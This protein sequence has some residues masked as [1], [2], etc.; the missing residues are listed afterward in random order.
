MK[1]GDTLNIPKMK[2]YRIGSDPEA[3]F[4]RP[5]DF[6]WIITPAFDIIGRDKKKTTNSFIGTDNR[7]VIAEI[8]PNPSRNLKRHLYE[9][10]YALTTTNDYLDSS[11]KWKGNKIMAYPYLLGE[12]LGGHIHASMFLD[13]PIYLKLKATGL[14]VGAGGLAFADY[15]GNVGGFAGR[16]RDIETEATTAI[17]ERKIIT[18]NLWGRAMGFLL[19]PFEKW[20]QPW[21]AR[22]ARNAHYGS[23]SSPDAVRLGTSKVPFELSKMAYVHWEYR[24]PS[25]W[26]QHP[27]LAYAYLGLA[28]LTL[29]N[30]AAVFG[31]WLADN[32][33]MKPPKHDVLGG[34]LAEPTMGDGGMPTQF[35]ILTHG[36]PREAGV[37]FRR[38]LSRVLPGAHFSRDLANLIGVVEKCATEREKWFHKPTPIDVEAWRK[39]L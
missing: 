17:R 38:N 5:V 39:L 34:T 3:L 15:N 19:T 7:P 35:T 11:E 27:W 24:L 12:N 16:N 13:D 37:A 23:E 21:V 22:E 31:L 8:R 1:G 25:T 18:P 4:V 33:K 32:P 10:A 36:D 26:L 9:I 30:M 29:L 20:V 6:D 2:L 28:K 14:T